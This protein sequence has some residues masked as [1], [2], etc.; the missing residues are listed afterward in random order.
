ML[1]YFYLQSISCTNCM[2]S[3]R[4]KVLKAIGATS[5]ASIVASGSSGALHLNSKNPEPDTEFKPTDFTDVKEA[6]ERFRALSEEERR[7]VLSELGENQR[8]ALA[9]AFRPASITKQRFK[10]NRSGPQVLTHGT[11]LLS[12]EVPAKWGWEIEANPSQNN[13]LEITESRVGGQFETSESKPTESN[14]SQASCSIEES[15]H[16]TYGDEITAHSFAGNLLFR[17]RHEIEWDYHYCAGGTGPAYNK[18]IS[19]PD[20]LSYSKH[21]DGVWSYDGTLKSDL[22]TY[23]SYCE[24][25]RQDTYSGP[26]IDKYPTGV[27]QPYSRLEGDW[28]GAGQTLESG[29]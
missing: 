7:E 16:A 20:A 11:K 9:D 23:D 27:I 14:S 10:S 1:E 18:S 13:A 25:F 19:N 26:D 6:S 4:R 22:D 3:N 29:K 8:E 2:S 21:T 15:G 28:S 24:S 17:W 12:K 5:L